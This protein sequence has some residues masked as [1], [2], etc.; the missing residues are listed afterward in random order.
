MLGAMDTTVSKTDMVPALMVLAHK[1]LPHLLQLPP[2][3]HEGIL[4][5]HP[6]SLDLHGFQEGAET[7]PS[8]DTTL[9]FPAPLNLFQVKRV[10]EEGGW[11]G[12]WVWRAEI[13][14]C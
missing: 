12:H 8:T 7:Q 9:G 10:R 14:C 11:G 3:G 1:E 4:K 2:E 6:T 5:V 13:G